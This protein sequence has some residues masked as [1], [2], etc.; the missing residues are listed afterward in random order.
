MLD[1]V[2]VSRESLYEQVWC[3]PVLKVATR[4]QIS[5][6]ALAKICRKMQIPVPPPGYWAR[7]QHG[8]TP[9]RPDLPSLPEGALSVASIEKRPPR[10]T[11]SPDIEAHIAR[12]AEEKNQIHVAAR[13]GRAHA[14][15]HQAGEVLRAQKP[16]ERGILRPPWRERCLDMR[17]SRASLPRALR[18][19]DAL[20]K[21]VERRGFHIATSEGERVATHIEGLGEKVEIDREERSTRQE[22]VLSN[23]ERDSKAKRGWT[24][25]PRWDYEPSGIL[26]LRIKE[27]WGDRI[28]KSWSDGRKHKLEDLL[29]DVITGI[30]VAADAKK[31]H[32][33]DLERQ[34]REWAEAERR[35]VE[36]EQQRRAEEQR[37]KELESSAER[38][39]KS[40]WLHSYVEAVERAARDAGIPMV[41]DNDL[42]RWLDWANRHAAR[43][44]PIPAEVARFGDL[45]V[46][47]ASMETGPSRE[48]ASG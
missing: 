16:D 34:Q 24:H 21:A 40:R 8:Y 39:A 29:N 20:L 26:Q 14:L 38:W 35:R 4:Y 25:E 2:T 37:L 11:P 17:V 13:L 23:E 10:A 3:E 45:K 15:V 46:V 32:R 48:T 44:D 43:L 7:K 19:M 42:G 47:R 31:R 18:I 30:I 22:H 5:G 1:H 27:V 12:E 9:G 28:R 33:L 41:P 36:L 6:T